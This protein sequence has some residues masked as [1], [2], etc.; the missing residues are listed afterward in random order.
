[1]VDEAKAD[2]KDKKWDEAQAVVQKLVDMKDKLSP[3]LQKE[4]DTLKT[5]ID[6]K[7]LK[8]PGNLPSVPGTPDNK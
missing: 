2:I 5:A 4:V 3:D 7:N 1:M 6:A 8:V